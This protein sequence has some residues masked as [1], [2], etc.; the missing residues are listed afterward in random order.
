MRIDPHA[1]HSLT[2][3]APDIAQEVGRLAANRMGGSQGLRGLAADPP[4][5]RAIVVGERWDPACAELR[6]FLDRN[7][8]T[9][10]T[11]GTGV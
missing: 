10:E 11:T 4:P 8:I 9:A 1:Y 6:R 3:V 7:Q 5:P 2:A